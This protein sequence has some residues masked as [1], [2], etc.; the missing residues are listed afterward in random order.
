GRRGSSEACR[1][2]RPR[3][4]RRARDDAESRLMSNRVVSFVGAKGGS[5]TTSIALEVTR[6][7]GRTQRVAV[8]DADLSGRRNLAVMLDAVRLFDERRG[9]DGIP[10]VE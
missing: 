9:Q 2:Q 1:A 10:V 4:H 5:G 6:A 8:V 3:D 7:L